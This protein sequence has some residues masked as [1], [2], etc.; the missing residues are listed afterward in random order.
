MITIADADAQI[1]QTDL[2]QELYD[3]VLRQAD[4]DP[5]FRRSNAQALAPIQAQL[6]DLLRQKGQYVEG[7]K[8]VDELIRS[9]PKS[10]AALMVKGQI[11]QAWAETE[12][13]Q[14]RASRRALEHPPRTSYPR[15]GRN[16]RSIST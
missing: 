15:F 10:L 6:V 3:R 1:G 8:Q 16:R 12:P 14:F 9:N 13:A 4:A 11:L 7:L 2:A 5:A